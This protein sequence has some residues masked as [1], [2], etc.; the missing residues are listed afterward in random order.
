MFKQYD[1]NWAELNNHLREI[2]S[3]GGGL[4]AALSKLETHH[5]ETGFIKKL[6]GTFERTKYYH[7]RDHSRFLRIQYNPER[8]LRF[9]GAGVKTP[10]AGT[11]LHNDGCFLCRDNIR[12]QQN[13][14]EIGYEILL[15]DNRYYAWMNPFPLLP[16]HV[17]VASRKHTSQEW[18]VSGDG[19]PDATPVLTDFIE[20]AKRMPGYV[21]FYNG[22]HAGASIPGHLHFQFCRRPEDDPVFPLEM[23]AERHLESDSDEVL[24]KEYPLTVAVW[25]G[26]PEDVLQRASSWIAGWAEENHHRIQELSANFIV[27][28][29]VSDNDILFFFVPR[30]RNKPQGDGLSGLIGGLE[31]LGEF[32]FSSEQDRSLLDRGQI[33]YFSLE[34]KLAHINT[35]FYQD[36]SKVD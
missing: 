36:Q 33:D 28:G 23:A 31:V 16:T 21:G 35:P 32:V 18:P 17:V 6:T 27:S 14:T 22:V 12:W 2:E 29:P 30:H 8:A 20:L 24:I 9:R 10:P 3:G 5:Q 4:V 34:K 26:T 15:K 19:Y 11:E 25:S 1:K 7:P 13:G